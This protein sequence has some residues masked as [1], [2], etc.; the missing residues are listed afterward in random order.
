MLTVNVLACAACKS[1][2]EEHFLRIKWPDT[3]EQVHTNNLFTR[4]IVTATAKR[5]TIK[6]RLTGVQKN[7]C[8]GEYNSFLLCPHSKGTGRTECVSLMH[9]ICGPFRDQVLMHNLF[10]R[11][12]LSKIAE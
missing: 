3:M 5:W 9:D 1:T 6:E 10:L 4:T 12:I 8:L 7:R 2:D 11:I